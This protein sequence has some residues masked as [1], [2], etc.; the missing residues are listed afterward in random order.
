MSGL[1]VPAVRAIQPPPITEI[2]RWQQRAVDA[3]S[4]PLIDL[5]QA[6]PDYPPP[7][8][9]LAQLQQA[10]QQPEIARYTPDEGLV[11]VR[12]VVSDWYRRRYG[13][14]PT[15]DEILLTIGAS[16]AFWLAMTVL[17][18]AGDEVIVQAPAYFDHPMALQSF[19][20]TPVF[21][22][23]DPALQGLPDLD[24]L[25]RLITPRTRA[26][27]LVTPSNPTG[28]VITPP[29]VAELLA[30]A[31]RHDIALVLD[32]TY[33]AFVDGP[34]HQLFSDPEWQRNFIHIA[35]FGKTFALTGFRAGALVAGSAVLREALKV[36]DSMA[37]CQPRLTQLAVQFGC[38]ALDDWV[39]DNARM[40]RARSVAFRHAF[41]DP[42][43]DFDLSASGSFFAWVSHPWPH[44]GSWDV[45]RRLA[46][47]QLVCLPGAA[48]GPD[49]DAYLRM[50]IGNLSVDRFAS[51]IDRLIEAQKEMS[52]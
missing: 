42:R 22:P 48:F 2:R 8:E 6:V 1:V 3:E 16:Q 39:E 49:L 46:E 32:E 47:S 38:E 44:L 13:A 26:L 51:A 17:C 5:C 35:S 29:L 41:A 33:N 25:E 9:L 52:A 4:L 11:E 7:P 14:A 24:R 50:A 15:A 18:C 27:L 43:L 30:L 45:A 40:M 28:A 37:V 31:R 36:Q 21:A 34:P 20:V 12:T 23:Y 10:L 19:G